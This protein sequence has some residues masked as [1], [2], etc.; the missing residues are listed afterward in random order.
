[1]VTADVLCSSQI[2]D[3]INIPELLITSNDD[4]VHP[5]I[6][7]STTR[8]RRRMGCAIRFPRMVRPDSSDEQNPTTFWRRHDEGR[9]RFG[10]ISNG[11]P[12]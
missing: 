11:F 6:D 8:K 9:C 7:Y 3:L 10:G 12:P 1:M 4:D 5:Q 2:N